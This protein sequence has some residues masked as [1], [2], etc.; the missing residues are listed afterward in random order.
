VTSDSSPGEGKRGRGR[1]TLYTPELVEELLD[2]LYEGGSLLAFCRGEGR[3]KYRTVYDWTARH[4]TFSAEFARA[5]KA[6]AAMRFEKA[7]EIVANATVET[8]QLAKL[9]AE[10]EYKAAACFDPGTFGQKARAADID[11]TEA[12]GAFRAIAEA[13]VAKRPAP[14]PEVTEAPPDAAAR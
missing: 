9:Q 1:P 2:W 6:G 4:E 11:P 7:G 3:P 14:P 5:R 10:H 13:I 12:I 8:V